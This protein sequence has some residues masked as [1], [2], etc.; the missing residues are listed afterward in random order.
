MSDRK[1]HQ[2]QRVLGPFL[3]IAMS[4]LAFYTLFLTD[5][6]LLRSRAPLV[7]H[8]P[9]AH[10]LRMGDPVLVAG[11]RT[12]RVR[13]ISLDESAELA[14]RIT[15]TMHM[16][17][18]VVLREGFSIRIEEATMLGGRQIQIDPG[19]PGAAVLGADAVL[20]GTVRKNPLEALGSLVSDS[21][22]PINELVADAAEVMASLRAGRGALGR[23]LTDE[24]LAEDLA[25]T[26]AGLSE[27]STDVAALTADL[28]AGRGTLGKLMTED[29]I[30][31]SA[32]RIAGELELT[33]D[34][35]ETLS[36]GLVEGQGTLG[37]MLRDEGL[38]ENVTTAIASIRSIA[39]SIDTGEGTIG[40]LVA[41]ETIAIN[42]RDVSQQLADGEGTMGALLA[43]DELY[44]N[45]LSASADVRE[46]VAKVRQ[47]EGTLGKIMVEKELYGQA[48]V[49]VQLLN[50]S[51]EDYRE[52]APITSFTSVLFAAF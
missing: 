35:L 48:L 49:A 19:P 52:A 18:R 7:A 21:E 20:L 47:G 2:Q 50:R 42:L 28:R 38:R 4:V 29:E 11:F 1:D 9:E 22:A 10:Q 33:L 25:Q 8:F 31:E 34:D 13:G 37:A 15:V 41:D 16:D 14:R 5:F 26:F 27:A 3:V 51:L 46:V 44:Q 45:L 30:Y 17:Q 24:D 23:A 12:G 39:E 40:H 32:K 36:S 43:S 6:S